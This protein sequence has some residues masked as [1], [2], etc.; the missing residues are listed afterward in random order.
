MDIRHLTESW[1]LR[2]VREPDIHLGE[3]PICSVLL[4]TPC[5][6]TLPASLSLPQAWGH[7]STD[8]KEAPAAKLDRKLPS[9]LFIKKNYI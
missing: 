8:D 2:G 4:T 7:V 6:G 5:Q 3:L 9:S 1:D